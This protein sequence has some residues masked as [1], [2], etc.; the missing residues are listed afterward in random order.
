MKN[1]ILASLLILITLILLATSTVNAQRGGGGWG[2]RGGHGF[3]RSG[4]AW[5]NGH[6][7]PGV[8]H[9]PAQVRVFQVGSLPNIRG[10][11][12]RFN[13]FFGKAGTLHRSFF[14]QGLPNSFFST[15]G[16]VRFHGSQL[17]NNPVPPLGLSPLLPTEPPTIFSF[18]ILSRHRPI[19]IVNVTPGFKAPA[20]SLA[21]VRQSGK[22]IIFLPDW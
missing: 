5:G 19:T 12:G 17:G 16:R 9:V 21:K 6:F 2:G 3:G 22:T 15:D 13:P 11:R 1:N 18:D 4:S 8:G 14:H 7:R 10:A 20:I